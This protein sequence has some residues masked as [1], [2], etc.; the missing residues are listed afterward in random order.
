M[1]AQFPTP[2][3]WLIPW[4][5]RVHVALYKLTAGRIGGRLAGKPGLLL[6]TIGARSGKA[7]TVCLPYL[8]L[9]DDRVIV[10]SYAGAPK[11]PAWYFNLRTNPEVIVRDHAAVFLADARILE[12]DEYAEVWAKVVADAPWYADYQ[13]RT[14][15]RIPLVRLVRTADL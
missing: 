15:R 4:I 8:P 14:E 3:R 2:P 13:A 1:A 7:H 12:G 9:D 6:R 5:S 11:H 10:A